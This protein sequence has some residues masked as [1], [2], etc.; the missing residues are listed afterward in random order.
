MAERRRRVFKKN[1]SDSSFSSTFF[2]S[3][4]LVWLLRRICN[5]SIM[6]VWAFLFCVTTNAYWHILIRFG[7]WRTCALNF[8]S[9]ILSKHAG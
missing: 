9:F 1:V 3:I 2:L 7:F 8:L 4:N 6:V 5:G